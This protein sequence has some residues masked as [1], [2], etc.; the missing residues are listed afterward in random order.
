MGE[1]AVYT[2]YVSASSSFV[3]ETIAIDYA[4]AAVAGLKAT[5]ASLLQLSKHKVAYRDAKVDE[6]ERKF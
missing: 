5:P 6:V 3:A 1:W 2:S 4:M